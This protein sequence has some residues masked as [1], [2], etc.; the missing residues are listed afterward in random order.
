VGGGSYDGTDLMPEIPPS[1]PNQEALDLYRLMIQE[2]Y[3]MKNELGPLMPYTPCNELQ[4]YTDGS[5]FYG[6]PNDIG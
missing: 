3:D 2:Y 1:N 5:I 4:Y 6:M